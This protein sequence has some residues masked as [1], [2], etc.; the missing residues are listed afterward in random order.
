MIKFLWFIYIELLV[1]YNELITY[2]TLKS[3]VLYR[4]YDTKLNSKCVY[5]I[6]NFTIKIVFC[7]K[8]E[9]K[10]IEAFCSSRYWRQPLGGLHLDES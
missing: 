10:K 6:V 7:F 9:C 2:L 4:A 5:E 8:Q 1:F 3:K